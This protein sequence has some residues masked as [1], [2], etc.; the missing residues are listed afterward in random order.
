LSSL[1]GV[2]PPASSASLDTKHPRKSCSAFIRFNYN[3]AIE[4]GAVGATTNPV[5]VEQVLSADLPRYTPVIKR[6]ASK[7]PPP[8]KTK[9]ADC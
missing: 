8:P 4:H 1:P 9:S 2:S 6:L 7:N 5:I 3:F